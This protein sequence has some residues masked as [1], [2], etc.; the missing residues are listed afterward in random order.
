MSAGSGKVARR[1][2][3]RT[4]TGGAAL[5]SLGLPGCLSHGP[6]PEAEEGEPTEPD[7]AKRRPNVLFVFADQFRADLCAGYGD[8]ALRNIETPHLDR[9]AD[10]GVTFTTALSTTPKCTPYRGMLMTGK[11]PTHSGLVVNFVQASPTANPDCLAQVFARAGYDTGFI[12]KWHLARGGWRNPGHLE[13]PD[14]A[15]NFVPPGPARLGFKHWEAYNFHVDFGSY[16]FFRDGPERQTSDRYETDAQ[17]DQAIRFLEARKGSEKPFFLVVAPH[18]PHPPFRDTHVPEGYLEGVP[19]ELKWAPNVPE[20]IRE[21][22]AERRRCYLAMAK[23][24]D[25]NMGR[26]MAYLDEAGLA[27]DTIVVFTSDHGEMHGSQGR[28]AK[29][30]P[31]A[32]SVNV[33]L[34]LRWP[35]RIPAGRREKTIYTP[36]DHLPTLCGLA[37][38]DAPEGLDGID[39]SGPVLGTG[40]SDREDVLMATYVSHFNTFTTGKPFREWRG[41]HSGKYTYFR[42]IEVSGDEMPAEELYDN[43]ADPHQ[44]TNLAKDPAHAIRM[45]RFRKR[46]AVLLAEAHDAFQPGTYYAGWY[47]EERN[48]IRTGL[49]PVKK[50]T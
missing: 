48:L 13:H 21:N 20:A 6:H 42:W 5:A 46:L 29:K 35:G 49:G 17:V 7:G 41:V 2:F 19:K 39:L 11:Y 30:V 38:L 36:M 15:E 18:P 32:E 47:D 10:Q 28:H 43:E 3:L 8:P 12:G 1:D 34:I 22:H 23:N 31:Y 45:E 14:I 16:W 9:L 26:L 24:V 4:L 44:M 50:M 33:P 37:G 25:D 40:T 27:S